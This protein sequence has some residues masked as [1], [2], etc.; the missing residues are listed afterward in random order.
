[1]SN[2]KFAEKTWKR[3]SEG[4]VLDEHD[5]M[6]CLVDSNIFQHNKLVSQKLKGSDIFFAILGLSCLVGAISTIMG[7]V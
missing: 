7:S 4:K 2:E 6:Q 5:L 1:M 3:N